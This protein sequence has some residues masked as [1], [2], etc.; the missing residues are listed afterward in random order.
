M[1]ITSALLALKDMSAEIDSELR[2]YHG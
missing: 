2:W 1:L